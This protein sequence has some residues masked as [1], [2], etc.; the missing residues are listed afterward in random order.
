MRIANIV[1]GAGFLALSIAYYFSALALP[2]SPS[3]GDPGPAELPK[4]IAVVM[5]I[6]AVILLIKSVGDTSVLDKKL[7][8]PRGPLLLVWTVG[9]ALA[10]PVAHT[11]PT[12]LVYVFGGMCIQLGRSGIKLGLLCAPLISLLVYAL[13]QMLLGVPLP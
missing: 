13:F 10:L 5:A 1:T 6:T 4:L 3:Y 2:F 11:V 8:P 9:A 12:L 7:F